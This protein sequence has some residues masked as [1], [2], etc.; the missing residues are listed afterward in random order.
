MG[1]KGFFNLKSSF[2]NALTDSYEYL[3][4]GST[5]ISNILHFSVGGSSLDVYGRRILTSESI[6][7]L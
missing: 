7:A 1:A 2:I 6:P 3:C 4:Y 5:A